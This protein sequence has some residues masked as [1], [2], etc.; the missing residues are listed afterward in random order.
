MQRAVQPG[1]T[2]KHWNGG[3]SNIRVD[4]FRPQ[5]LHAQMFAVPCV[6][7]Q[8]AVNVGALT[9]MPA[10]GGSAHTWGGRGGG[11]LS[12]RSGVPFWLATKNLFG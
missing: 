7:K 5:D 6:E 4:F 8:R 1:L 9:R 2:K 10:R 12:M 11:L 3:E